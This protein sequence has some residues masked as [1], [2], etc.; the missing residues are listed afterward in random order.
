[1]RKIFITGIGTDVGKTIVS[2]IFTEAFKADYWKPIQ[3]GLPRDSDA[4]EDLISNIETET[5]PERFLFGNAL[6]PHAA[7]RSE[8][9]EIKL[10]DFKLPS[11][12]NI[13]VIEGAGGLMVPLNNKELVIDLINKFDAEVVLVVKN[14][15]GNINHT[16]LSI[17]ALKNRKIKIAGLV[18]NGKMLPLT[19]EV[20]LKQSGLKCL[21][22]IKEEKEITKAVVLRYA[23]L[24]IEQL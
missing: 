24:L 17:E 22:R 18:F 4:I 15:L 11:A 2:A 14:Y 8:K 3:C 9:I 16:L 5:H 23:K 1:M 13:L 20:I 21:L 19:E 6:S 7:A 10:S 12:S